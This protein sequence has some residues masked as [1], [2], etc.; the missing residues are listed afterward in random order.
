MF[1]TP[2]SFW[3][4]QAVDPEL[5]RRIDSPYERAD[6]QMVGPH[7]W[8]G[9]EGWDCTPPAWQGPVP[10]CLKHDV[11]YGS[12]QKFAGHN[13]GTEDSNS[14]DLTWN[15]RNKHL[16][17]AVFLADIINHGC[18]QNSGSYASV[19][20]TIDA[21]IEQAYIMHLAVNR[22]N[23]KGWPVTRSDVRHT[24]ANPKYISCDVPRV[25]DV[26]VSKSSGLVTRDFNVSWTY[27]AGCVSEI[28][29]ERYMTCWDTTILGIRDEVC[30][31]PSGNSTTSRLRQ[32]K[33]TPR[34]VE[35]LVS[36]AIRPSDI[37]YGGV[38]LSTLL[39]YDDETIRLIEWLFEISP[40]ELVGIYYPDQR[41]DLEYE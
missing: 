20:C 30:E 14:L 32:P 17:D 26:R 31:Y 1:D 29:V 16:A 8:L 33:V 19:L 2:H 11:A 22:G 38:L 4:N 18:Q 27:R 12:L 13:S 5:Q 15:P 34:A 23:N 36:I 21:I 28:T 41:F 39:T 3:V 6:G 24:E 40:L 9:Y 37:Q 10:T 35:S 25:S 7:S